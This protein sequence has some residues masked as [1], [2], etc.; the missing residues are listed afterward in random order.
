MVSGVI[1]VSRRAVPTEGAVGR[2]EEVN[3]LLAGS[4]FGAGELLAGE[5]PSRASRLLCP[6]VGATRLFVPW[7]TTQNRR[8][9]RRFTTTVAANFFSMVKGARDL[10]P[11]AVGG[12]AAVVRLGL[13]PS[14]F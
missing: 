14:I 12:F 10:T 1:R 3:R 9:H 13:Y 5:L 7:L 4:I 6:E 8:A 11:G 2:D